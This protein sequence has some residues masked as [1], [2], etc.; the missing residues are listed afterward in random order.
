MYKHNQYCLS[1]DYSQGYHLSTPQNKHVA[2]RWRIKLPLLKISC[3]Q[4]NTK[5]EQEVLL[6]I[7]KLQK[8]SKC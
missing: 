4:N 1:T 5:L 8:N 3:S 2:V 7:N 6:A